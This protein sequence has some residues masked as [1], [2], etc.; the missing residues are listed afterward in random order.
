VAIY[1]AIRAAGNQVTGVAVEQINDQVLQ[2]LRGGER[3]G[4]YINLHA[5]HDFHGVVKVADAARADSGDT[6]A[7]ADRV[8]LD[9]CRI[10][11]RWRYNA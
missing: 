7:G 1:D 9:V 4:K 8:T 3:S 5:L 11:L 10:N 6:D 2:S